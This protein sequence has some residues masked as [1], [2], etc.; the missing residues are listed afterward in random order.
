MGQDHMKDELRFSTMVLGAL[1]AT[2]NGVRM[3]DWWCVSNWA[4]LGLRP[5]TRTH[6]LEKG[7]AQFCLT[8]CNALVVRATSYSV[9]MVLLTVSMMKM[10]E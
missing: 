7:L 5:H 3:M 4:T 9:Q 6:I 8:I 1:C 2:M 10:P